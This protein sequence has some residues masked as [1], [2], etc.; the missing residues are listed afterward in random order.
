MLEVLKQFRVLLRAMDAHYRRVEARSGLGGAQLWALAEIAAADGMTMSALADKLAIQL[1][2]ASNLV[3][4]LEALGLVSR[5]R[6]RKDQRVVTLAATAAGR[7]KLKRAPR[8]STGLLQGAL[9]DMP[10]KDLRALRVQLNALLTRMGRPGRGAL[11]T[12]IADILG[13]R[14]R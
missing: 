2:T 10:R 12:P 13:A 1:S 9:M 3:S 11:G 7:R 8:P 5:A 14:G 6:R 4:R